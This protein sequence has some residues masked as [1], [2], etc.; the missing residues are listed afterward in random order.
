MPSMPLKYESWTCTDAMNISFKNGYTIALPMGKLIKSAFH[1]AHPKPANSLLL[2]D[3]LIIMKY[4]LSRIFNEDCFDL[5]SHVLPS[6]LSLYISNQS[7]ENVIFED[8]K[9]LDS[10]RL[11]LMGTLAITSY[12]KDNPEISIFFEQCVMYYTIHCLHGATSSTSKENGFDG[13]IIV[14]AISS[15][16]SFCSGSDIEIEVCIEKSLKALEIFIEIAETV[17]GIKIWKFSLFEQIWKKVCLLCYEKAWHTQKFVCKA[18]QLLFNKCPTDWKCIHLVEFIKHLFHIIKISSLENSLNHGVCTLAGTILQ[19]TFSV[20]EENLKD[21]LNPVLE[22]SVTGMFST[23]E[24]MRNQ[25]NELFKFLRKISSKQVELMLPDLPGIKLMLDNLSRI[26][27]CLESVPLQ[28]K[29]GILDGFLF[30]LEVWPELLE[31]QGARGVQYLINSCNFVLDACVPFSKISNDHT[32]FCKRA[33]KVLFFLYKKDSAKE[34]LNK[35]LQCDSYE[36]FSVAFECCLQL[37]DLL[38]IRQWLKDSERQLTDLPFVREMKENA[39]EEEFPTIQDFYLLK[40]MRHMSCLLVLL[41]DN[42]QER[43]QYVYLFIFHAVL[44][45]LRRSSDFSMEIK[46]RRVFKDIFFVHDDVKDM[47]LDV[48]GSMFKFNPERIVEFFIVEFLKANNQERKLLISFFVNHLLQGKWGRYL[49]PVLLNNDPFVNDSRL[50]K[51]LYPLEQEFFENKYIFL[52]WMLCG[53]NRSRPRNGVCGNSI[54]KVYSTPNELTYFAIELIYCLHQYDADILKEA[55]IVYAL[56]KIWSLLEKRNELFSPRI[57]SFSRLKEHKKLAMLLMEIYKFSNKIEFLFELLKAPVDRFPEHFQFLTEFLKAEVIEKQSDIWKKEAFGKFVLYHANKSYSTNVEIKILEHLIIPSFL[58]SVRELNF[59][60]FKYMTNKDINEDDKDINKEFQQGV[61]VCFEELMK[62]ECRIKKP[63]LQLSCLLLECACYYISEDFLRELKAF[64]G[65]YIQ[66]SDSVQNLYDPLLKSYWDLF[67]TYL[68]KIVKVGFPPDTYSKIL[69]NSLS[70]YTPDVREVS[71]YTLDVLIP[72]MCSERGGALFYVHWTSVILEDGSLSICR[73][74]PGNKNLKKECFARRLHFEHIYHTIVNNSEECILHTGFMHLLLDVIDGM[75]NIDKVKYILETF[76]I[77][78]ETLE[79]ILKNNTKLTPI[80]YLS[81]RETA[82]SVVEM[83]FKHPNLK[84]ENSKIDEMVC[85]KIVNICKKIHYL[86]SVG[87]LRLYPNH[88]GTR[89]LKDDILEYLRRL[90][91]NHCIDFILYLQRVDVK[92]FDMDIIDLLV[93]F[94][95]TSKMANLLKSPISLKK[96]QKS[97]WVKFFKATDEFLKMCFWQPKNAVSLDEFSSFPFQD[98]AFL[99][100]YVLDLKEVIK[101]FIDFLKKM[102]ENLVLLAADFSQSSKQKFREKMALYIN[103]KFIRCLLNLEE[104]MEADL[105][106]KVG[107]DPSTSLKF[108]CNCLYHIVGWGILKFA[109]IVFPECFNSLEL[110][111]LVKKVLQDNLKAIKVANTF[112]TDEAKLIITLEIIEFGFLRIP[113]CEEIKNLLFGLAEVI[114]S[115]EIF[116]SIL[117]IIRKWFIK[118]LL[119]DNCVKDS[120]LN[121]VKMISNRI[122]EF[123]KD[124][125]VCNEL[126]KL[127]RLIYSY[128]ESENQYDPFS[129]DSCFVLHSNIS[130]TRIKFIRMCDS[131]TVDYAMKHL[132]C[133]GMRSSTPFSLAHCFE[134]VTSTV[135]EMPMESS[136]AYPYIEAQSTEKKLDFILKSLSSFKADLCKINSSSFFDAVLK[137]CKVDSNLLKDMWSNLFPELWSIL[138]D[139]NEENKSVVEQYEEFIKNSISCR[140]DWRNNEI[141]IFVDVF[142]S[143]YSLPLFSHSFLQFVGAFPGLPKK[144]YLKLEDFILENDLSEIPKYEIYLQLL[145]LAYFELTDDDLL[146]GFHQQYS[147]CPE[148]RAGIV[149]QNLGDFYE[150]LNEYKDAMKRKIV[151]Q[152]ENEF[153][154]AEMDLLRSYRIKCSK[155]LGDWN[156][157]KEID[158]DLE[159]KDADEL[160]KSCKY[161]QRVFQENTL[162]LSEISPLLKALSCACIEK[163]KSQSPCLFTPSYGHLLQTGRIVLEFEKAFHL[164]TVLQGD[165]ADFDFSKAASIFQSWF[166]NMPSLKDDLSFWNDITIHRLNQLNICQSYIMQNVPIEDYRMQKMSVAQFAYNTYIKALAKTMYTRGLPIVCVKLLQ[167]CKGLIVNEDN[168]ELYLESLLLEMKLSKNDLQKNEILQEKVCS[169]LQKEFPKITTEAGAAMCNVYQ[170]LILS[171][172]N[173]H[174]TNEKIIE[175]MFFVSY[176]KLTDSSKGWLYCGNFFQ[177]RFNSRDERCYEYALRSF[178][179]SCKYENITTS[180]EPLAKIIWLLSHS[181]YVPSNLRNNFIEDITQIPISYWLA[182]IPQLL[183]AFLR[184]KDCHLSYILHNISFKHPAPLY[185][186]LDS[187]MKDTNVMTKDEGHLNYQSCLKIMDAMKVRHPVLISS[188]EKIM[189]EFALLSEKIKPNIHIILQR[190]EVKICDLL[191][192]YASKPITANSIDSEVQDILIESQSSLESENDPEL[193]TVICDLLNTSERSLENTLCKLSKCIRS[194]SRKK[195]SKKSFALDPSSFLSL[196]CTDQVEM[197]VNSFIKNQPCVFISRILPKIDLIERHGQYAC[198]VFIE[199][200]NGKVYPYVIMPNDSMTSFMKES[201]I[202]QFFSF[203]NDLLQMEQET[204][205]RCLKFSVPSIMPINAKFKIVEDDVSSTSLLDIFE[206]NCAKVEENDFMTPFLSL[207]YELYLKMLFSLDDFQMNA[208]RLFCFIQKYIISKTILKQEFRNRT[209]SDYY[210]LRKRFSRDMS[211]YYFA[212]FCFCLNQQIPE[213]L[214]IHQSDGKVTSFGFIFKN[215]NDV[216]V[217]SFSQEMPFPITPNIS[218]FITPI[219]IL[220]YIKLAMCATAHCFYR[221]SEKFESVLKAICLNETAD[222]F[223]VTYRSFNHQKICS[224][225]DLVTATVEGLAD[226][227]GFGGQIDH[228]IALS[229]DSTKL[230]MVFPSYYPWL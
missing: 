180:M 163:L 106:A 135:L 61:L 220:G 76:E 4:Y 100:E 192:F 80:K 186:L 183:A 20:I 222:L 206:K 46:C 151:E 173:E 116:I 87:F 79:K 5:L 176:R 36:L 28:S 29:V 89:L 74:H 179:S 211:L 139:D 103:I 119:Q 185:F 215:F 108:I 122:F 158:R 64:A 127:M 47:F 137:L 191:F 98:Y 118:D 15:F 67:T 129:L 50:S 83:M 8:V 104:L 81:L 60:I 189:K 121:I 42:L 164:Q 157:L 174:C 152:I 3:C 6:N 200:T 126:F 77:I 217:S 44:S 156:D 85:Q 145:S 41:K 219:G 102:F 33:F 123:S 38:P 2:K 63:L 35:G 117:N 172:M 147:K 23:C 21:C 140:N 75:E 62:S 52:N 195:K 49:L 196:F 169:F 7:L 107:E 224:F 56:Q 48:V 11:V 132:P 153:D 165:V 201:R 111:E 218:T 155:Q 214:Y 133:I 230:S 54:N 91:V 128:Y 32:E 97:A 58:F 93:F 115:K 51:I 204:A 131:L 25:S 88:P 109:V 120:V 178:I 136:G 71:T 92:I 22:I 68:I 45:C 184:I 159:I 146:S 199:G 149:H 228:L 142:F 73:L 84:P 95:E 171:K 226:I 82:S 216:A 223:T 39:V 209:P 125:H 205:K 101:T 30:F 70:F 57:H 207:Y 27:K 16:L 18:M 66:Q 148:L 190:I 19:N 203:L 113:D 40:H 143:S 43:D 229:Q 34:L 177:K 202:F 1:I 225:V 12:N 213:K 210:E 114:K 90:S 221:H 138:L 99:K 188:L 14:D 162:P 110:I 78:L 112:N 227:R 166:Y 124:Y 197:F 154:Q 69:R 144:M 94:F 168:M 37:K 198:R 141:G 167:K 170:G 31:T 187:V 161:L 208:E 9:P 130:E 212:K 182:W 17:V 193:K 59:Y 181:S 10:H 96:V 175:E 105:D 13:F 53:G 55:S 194:Y 86:D 24:A 150:A 134:L 65:L 26:D 160:S 72:D